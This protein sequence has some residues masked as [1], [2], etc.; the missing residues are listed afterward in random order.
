MRKKKN[1]VGAADPAETSETANSAIVDQAETANSAIVDQAETADTAG[2]AEA[3]DS[4]ESVEVA[5]AVSS[6]DP[7][8]SAKPVADLS[9]LT[10]HVK[11]ASEMLFGAVNPF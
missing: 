10:P 5:E 4:P 1:L 2:A 11:A 3:V 7:A 9:N 8:V 6:D